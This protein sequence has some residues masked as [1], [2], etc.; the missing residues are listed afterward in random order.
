[1][2]Y[3]LTNSTEE[4]KFKKVFADF[5]IQKIDSF[6]MNP[7]GLESRSHKDRLHRNMYWVERL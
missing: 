2:D 1:M 4:N 3:I 7:V 6:D 5:H